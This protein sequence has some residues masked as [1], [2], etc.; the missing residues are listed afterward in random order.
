VAPK[1]NTSA[2]FRL[3]GLNAPWNLLLLSDIELHRFQ[4]VGNVAERA[5]DCGGKPVDA[6]RGCQ[7]KHQISPPQ[8]HHTVAC[9]AKNLAVDSPVSAN[10]F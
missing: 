5:L 3:H 9:T 7:Q 4:Y 8:R 10:G 1:L 2:L 6:A